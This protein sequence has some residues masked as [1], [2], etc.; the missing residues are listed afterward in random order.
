LRFGP[1]DPSALAFDAQTDYLYASDRASSGGSIWRF[2]L[3]PVTGNIERA[4]SSPPRA[5][6]S[7]R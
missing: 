2:R 5:I 7:R 4:R 6:G 1:A 3:D